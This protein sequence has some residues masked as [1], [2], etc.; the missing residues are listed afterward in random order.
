MRTASRRMGLGLLFI[1]ALAFPLVGTADNALARSVGAGNGGLA[2]A[3]ADAGS[4]QLGDIDSGGNVGNI[5]D[6]PYYV[7]PVDGGRVV[8]DTVIDVNV[9][10][11]TAVSRAA[12]RNGNTAGG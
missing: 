7:E 6:V 5:I 2:A 9:D 11:G 8:N 10:G 3:N 12:G 1:A 4:I